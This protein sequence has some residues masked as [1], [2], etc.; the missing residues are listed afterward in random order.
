M[1]A[2]LAG[3]INRLS[4][5]PSNMQEGLPTLV[6]DDT[7]V[8]RIESVLESEYRE[9]TF[10]D[11]VND[12]VDSL[13]VVRD[14]TKPTYNRKVYE[15]TI[16]ELIDALHLPTG[17]SVLKTATR[18]RVQ[19]ALT[20]LPLSSIFANGMYTFANNLTGPIDAQRIP[21]IVDRMNEMGLIKDFN[22]RY[23]FT[24]LPEDLQVPVDKVPVDPTTGEEM[25]TKDEQ[26][27][28]LALELNI[29]LFNNEEFA[30][31]P[32]GIAKAEQKLI[33]LYE[34]VVDEGLQDFV[35]AR[36]NPLSA[37]FKAD[38]TPKLV[39][40]D[41]RTRVVTDEAAPA[42]LM[43]DVIDPADWDGEIDPD[44][45]RAEDELG[46]AFSTADGTPIT[47]PMEI[48]RV[49]MQVNTFKNK[50]RVKPKTFVFRTQADLQAKDPALYARAVAARPQGD[51]D[52]K[53]AAGYSFGSGDDATV[54]IFSDRILDSQQLNFV[55]A[56]ET[57]GHFGMRSLLSQARFKSVMEGLYEDSGVD[58]NLRF[59]V[60]AA[61]AANP[62]LS[63]AQAVEEYLADFAG[64]LDTSIVR[65]IYNA[66]KGV[67]NRLGVQFSDDA[68]RYLIG[69]ARDYVRLGEVSSMFDAAKVATRI[70]ELNGGMDPDGT[71]RFSSSNTVGMLHMVAAFVSAPRW[72]DAGRALASGD[73][74]EAAKAAMDAIRKTGIN[75]KSD[76][77]G[78]KRQIWRLSTYVKRENE[79][80]EQVF[81][82][83]DRGTKE[84]YRIQNDFN[85]R[86]KLVF[87]RAMFDKVADLPAVG[88]A[89][90]TQIDSINR[91][92]YGSLMK[93]RNSYTPT[94]LGVE[95]LYTVLD[96]KY[97][98]NTSEIN[99]L[100]KL[101]T[102]SFEEMRDGYSYE[103]TDG[104][105]IEVE[106]IPDLTRD[107]IR[108][109]GYMDVMEALRDLQLEKVRASMQAAVSVEN[110]IFGKLDSI[111][112]SG[113]LEPQQRQFLES[114][115]RVFVETYYADPEFITGEDGVAV[116][117][118]N[119][120][121]MQ[122]ANDFL[123][124]LNT[125][126]IA[127]K[128]AATDTI[129]AERNAK[130]IEALRNTGRDID[131]NTE[132][133]IFQNIEDFK[134]A[135]VVRAKLKADENLYAIQTAFKA[136][137]AING[138]VE[139][140]IK[141]AKRN[142]AVGYVPFVRRGDW[143]M[144]VEFYDR[145][146]NKVFLTQEFKDSVV[147]RQFET[148]G[149]AVTV[150]NKVN[151][152]FDGV[153]NK[154][155]IKNSDEAIED[156]GPPIIEAEVTARAVPRKTLDTVSAPTGLDLATVTTFLHRFSIGLPP[157]KMQEIIVNLTTSEAAIRSK[158]QAQG[159]PGY[160]PN[161]IRAMAEFVRK[162]SS[163]IV[164]IQMRP[165]LNR[166]LDIS[167]PESMKLWRGDPAKLERLR[168]TWDL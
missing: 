103:L 109:K 39:Q 143:E 10:D 84:S 114:M 131:T 78:I 15:N 69:H 145:N 30:R 47:K 96:G 52:T 2:E 98:K 148:E 135:R 38:G 121:S 137:Q 156:G 20:D 17:V 68:A 127:E 31:N 158:L 34:R 159:T 149:D 43:T 40:R 133:E 53:V 51:F 117:V 11:D 147:Y 57:I 139:N 115:H 81:G 66:I 62:K 42:R 55:L 13:D 160:D 56:H 72:G 25:S 19:K 154:V 44:V 104:S 102:L 74:H 128:P 138:E 67:L 155:L 85:E 48:G 54:I 110:D 167:N 76:W 64:R 107:D 163:A 164:K 75:I 119:V 111:M 65:R 88:G 49:R 122:S 142:I 152:L 94:M 27:D 32:A 3:Q 106:G 144:A 105:V 132:A 165:E 151:E 23:G 46:G 59:Q 140:V 58:T 33:E 146:N 89:T 41:G 14:I 26:A 125:A 101:G 120:A 90:S 45:A 63:R 16:A 8:A 36:G 136:A 79:G 91:N 9:A 130:V 141:T 29:N 37:Y 6:V 99:R 80:L 21:F 113:E 97:L 92:L 83:F 134:A 12:L 1:T 71:G 108:Y 60:D 77:E 124:A 70:Q 22:N 162:E 168:T 82:L 93:N 95:P 87:D 7:G 116:E 50:L 86:L 157:A 61:M 129:A 5:T 118:E 18:A 28:A 4:S 150:T 153:Y 100:F 73:H 126:L 24:N 166:I 123:V 112:R 35:D 161:A